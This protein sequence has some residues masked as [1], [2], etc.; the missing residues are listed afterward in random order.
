MS[1]FR[2][3][4]L[5]SQ[6]GPTGCW[7]PSCI[8][9]AILAAAELNVSGGILGREVDLVVRDAGWDPAGAADVARSMLEVDRVGAIV[10]MVASNSRRAVSL[11]AAGKAPFIYTPNY[12][13]DAPEPTI[14]ISSTDNC[15]IGPLLDWATQ[16]YGARRFF[17]IGSDYKW[18]RASMP[19]TGRMIASR[20]GEVTGML[21]RPINAG[22]DWDHAAVERIRRSRPDMVLVL[23]VGDQSLPFYR[24]YEAA[25]L[26]QLIPRCALA[27]DETAL[28]GLDAN[29]AEGL[30]AAAFYFATARTRPNMAFMELYWTAFGEFAPMPNF[31]GQS[32]YEGVNFAAG[33]ARLA[34]SLDARAMLKTSRAS[35]AFRSARFE[36]AEG[37]L[38]R[39]LP[40]YIARAN[41]PVFDIV[42]RY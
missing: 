35:V 28:P 12:E 16:R 14:A 1:K 10:S 22:E 32:C 15:L 33:L 13:V 5:I 30:H 41:G 37:H 25:G 39:R 4:L 17:L 20:G 42:A 3:G 9:A 6:T 2:L 8:N 40:V 38:G 26:A 27:T 18:A 31:Y 11:A 21:A 36:T 23:L 7:A 34:G 24:A 29:C 19:M